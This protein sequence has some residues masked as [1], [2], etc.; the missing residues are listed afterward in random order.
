MNVLEFHKIDQMLYISHVTRP[1]I[2]Y[3]IDV[4]SDMRYYYRGEYA[5]LSLCAACVELLHVESIHNL[6]L[7][8][9]LVG[10]SFTSK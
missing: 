10:S 8:R 9:V 3:A 7:I 6:Q 5:T 4:E 1:H 2:I